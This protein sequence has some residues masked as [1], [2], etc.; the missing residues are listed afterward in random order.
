M[1]PIFTVHAGEYL[2]A[3]HVEQLYC[4]THGVRVWV[5]SK[6]DG[7]DLLV[8]S[9]DCKKT[10]SL[11][12]KFSKSYTNGK[13]CNSSG[14]WAINKAKLE[15]SKAHYW[16]FVMPEL[17]AEWKFNDCCFIIISPKILW[18]SIRIII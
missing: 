12:V 13:D 15:N 1:R 14:W 5:P 8:T 9:N 2:V 3:N 7:I 10:V 4:K 17:N 11:Q 16:V 6:D 18:K